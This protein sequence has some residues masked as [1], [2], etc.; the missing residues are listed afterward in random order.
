MNKSELIW[1]DI[2]LYYRVQLFKENKYKINTF[3]D[4]MTIWH[5]DH[6]Y[7]Y[8]KGLYQMFSVSNDDPYLHSLNNKQSN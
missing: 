1:F 8:Y 6:G 5:L 7:G 3:E 4:L 2:P